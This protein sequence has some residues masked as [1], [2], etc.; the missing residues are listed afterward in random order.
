MP[1]FESHFVRLHELQSKMSMKILAVVE[2]KFFSLLDIL[3]GVD[4]DPV[5]AVHHEDFHFAV[6]LGG[7]VGEPYLPSHPE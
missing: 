7:V 3:V 5:V 4:S 1:N 2:K 6:G